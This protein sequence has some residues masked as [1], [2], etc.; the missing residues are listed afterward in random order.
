MS[1]CPPEA[2]AVP[3]DAGLCV[4]LT[5]G[6][7]LCDVNASPSMVKIHPSWHFLIPSSP[8]SRDSRR[9]HAGSCATSFSPATCSSTCNR[10]LKPQC[11]RYPA[12]HPPPLTQVVCAQQTKP[13][14]DPRLMLSLPAYSIRCEKVGVPAATRAG[15]DRHPGRRGR[16]RPGS[17]DLGWTVRTVSNQRSTSTSALQVQRRTRFGVGLFWVISPTV[18]CSK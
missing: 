3:T 18:C 1:A 11:T 10:P 12:Q 5:R 15:A 16:G 7:A 14:P 8:G 4:G 2:S 9:C 6:R 13:T 17:L